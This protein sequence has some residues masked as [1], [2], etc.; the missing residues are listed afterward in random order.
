MH[1]RKLKK[2]AQVL[3]EYIPKLQ[4]ELAA[5]TDDPLENVMDQNELQ[6]KLNDYDQDEQPD[7]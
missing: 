3:V 2:K 7:I 4:E 1:I 6:N 5:Y